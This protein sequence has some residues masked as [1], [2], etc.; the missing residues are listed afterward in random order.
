VYPAK[1]PNFL[2]MKWAKTSIVIKLQ[3]RHNQPSKTNLSSTNLEDGEERLDHGHCHLQANKE[4]A[5][6]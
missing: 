3:Q 6:P 4:G 2:P 5:L 1:N